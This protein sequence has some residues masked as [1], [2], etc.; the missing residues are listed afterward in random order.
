MITVSNVGLRYGDRKLFDDVNIKFTPGNCYGLIGANGAGKSTF[1]KILSG[2]IEAQS[3]SVHL[4]PGERLAVLKQNHFEYEEF[5]VLKVVIMGHTR[6]YEVMQEKDAIYMKADFTDEDGMKA[7][8]LEGEF[9]EL[10]G[11]EAES[12]AAILLK[13]L[14]I[15]DDL[16]D[17]KM[18]ELNG[19][20]KVKVLLAQALFGKPDV[21]LLDEP[22]NHLDIKAIQWLEEFLINF[23]NTV[24]V[25]SHDRHFLNKVC[26]HIAD[27]DFSKIQIYVGNYDF[28]YE[29]S[30]LASRM[31]TDANRK[32][33]EKIK[34]LQNFIARFS[35]NASKS[36]QATS[37][38]KLLDKITL[39]D[40]RPSSRRYPYVGFTPEREIGNDLLRVEGISKTIEGVRVL[41]N[42]SFIVNKD[43]K[44]ALVGKDEIAKTTLFKILTGEMEP[45]SG[46]FKWGVTTSQAYFPKDNSEFFEGNELTLVDWLRQFSPN[47]QSESFLRGFLGR[48]LFSGEEVLK[49]ASVLSGGEKVRCM[50]SKMMLSGANVLL[51][52]EPTNHLDLESITALNNGLI[53]YKGSLIFS[54]HDHQF[55][56]TI[57]NRVMEITPNGLMDKQ[58]SYD[59]YLE[60]SELQKQVAALYE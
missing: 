12:E 23:E 54:S 15:P 31:A 44:I 21:L 58:M 2:E 19:G 42:I 51:L 45:D 50:L 55:I 9:A 43:D 40:I 22:T 46:S 24:I 13:G 57:A 25:V 35:A 26:T 3:G 38:K 28:W 29:S 8:E 32:K 5:E 56:E 11:W 27:L 60:N 18:E 6:L 47:D 1:L 39:D 17:K 59:E 34:E 48:M 10:N 37:R 14:G 20:D 49:K 33:E 7:A 52:D 53:N 36:K 30:Q 4:G 16:H 41:N